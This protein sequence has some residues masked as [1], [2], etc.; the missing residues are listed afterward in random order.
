MDSNTMI[1]YWSASTFM[2]GKHISRRILYTGVYIGSLTFEIN[3]LTYVIIDN[4]TW[5][6]F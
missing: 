1:H 2:I 3:H 6:P 5:G 4:A